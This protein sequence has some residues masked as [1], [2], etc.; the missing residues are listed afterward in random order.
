MTDTL[1]TPPRSLRGRIAGT[2][3]G[4]AFE[5]DKAPAR[6]PAGGPWRDGL[7]RGEVHDGNAWYGIGGVAGHAGLF[8]TATA[9]F[10]YGQMWLNGGVLGDTR[11]LP[12]D[13]VAEAIVNHTPF[14]AKLARG[15]GWR[16]MP[17]PGTPEE[18]PDSGRGLSGSAFGHTGFTGTSLY[19]DPERD[20]L[21]V[22]LTNRV[23]PTVTTAYLETRA[24]F[25]AAI[26]DAIRD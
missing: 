10:R 5:G 24:H 4:N 2:E 12:Q 21:I 16:L 15:Y 14:D 8:G 7:I 25:S 20:L 9:L 23:H 17:P 18:T 3:I 1:F 26:V 6:S 11:I 19:M 22:L 13:L